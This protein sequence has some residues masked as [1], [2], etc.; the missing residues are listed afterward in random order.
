VV[1]VWMPPPACSVV[2]PCVRPFGGSPA[3]LP[4]YRIDGK[5]EPLD[6]L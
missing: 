1:D 6:T 4:A 3:S 5:V 2:S